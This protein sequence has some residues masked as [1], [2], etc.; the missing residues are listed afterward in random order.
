MSDT[1]T[2]ETRNTEAGDIIL[3]TEGITKR[4]GALIV[5]RGIDIHLRR[6]EVLGL[7]GD[8]GSGKSTFVKILCGF[9]RADSGHIFVN[10]HEVTLRSV[11]E[12]RSHGIETVYQDLALVPALTVYQ[13]LFL[14][15]E[16][17]RFGRLKWLRNNEMRKLARQYL[18][19]IKVDVPSVDALVETLS[20]GQRQAVA[21]A[22]ATRQE[23]KVLLLDEPLAAMGAKESAL[24]IE[25]VKDLSHNHGV[26]M[27]VID[28]NY[29]HLFELC[30]RL[31]VLQEGQITYDQRVKDTSIEE[32]TELMVADYRRRVSVGRTE[33]AN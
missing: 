3:R 24:V 11:Q 33:L 18:S 12:A 25:L 14:N 9:H 20:G 30:D 2:P 4:F 13:N 17:T 22:R 16:L 27:I 28:H 21:L 26:S 6:G 19:D 7:V 32:L 8:N 29:T 31:N 15:R 10:E 23:A 5:L 1:G